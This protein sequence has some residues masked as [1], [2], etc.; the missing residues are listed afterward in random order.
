MD[1]YIL[2]A[3]ALI[4]Y[5]TD[6]EGADIVQDM[7]RKAYFEECEVS[8]S[9]INLLEVFYDVYKT[10]GETEAKNFL[11]NILNTPVKII[12]TIER[13]IFIEAGRLK[14]NYRVSLADS[15]FSSCKS[16]SPAFTIFATLSAKSR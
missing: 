10:Q 11:Y 15:I 8:I 1:K 2:D 12:E 3:C 5:Y 4:A 14:A 7:I 13:D 16:S 9:K 6:E